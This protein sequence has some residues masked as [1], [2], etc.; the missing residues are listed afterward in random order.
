MKDILNHTQEGLLPLNI[1]LTYHPYLKMNKIQLFSIFLHAIVMTSMMYGN[2]VV[3]VNVWV[4]GTNIPPDFLVL[5]PKSPLRPWLYAKPGLSL[6]RELPDNYYYHKLAK[7]CHASDP[8]NF[9]MEH[10]YTFGWPSSVPNATVRKKHGIKLANQL[11]NLLAWYHQQG[12]KVNLRIIGFSHG[13]NVILNMLSVLPFAHKPEQ[14]EV[15]LLAVPVQ[16]LTRNHIN[17]PH[18]CKAYSFYSDADKMQELDIQKLHNWS[19][20][21]P[22]FSAKLFHENDTIIQVNLRIAGIAIGHREY[23]SFN[24]LLPQIL[25]QVDQMLPQDQIKGHVLL[26]FLSDAHLNCYH[27]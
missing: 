26:D 17:S 14:L 16:E 10:F 9:S 3:S 6:A 1:F 7:A 23:R 4:H 19:A 13:G 12:V 2:D 11:N 15:V 18:V 24:H 22:W 8:H 21:V 27:L 20:H 25:K 5:H